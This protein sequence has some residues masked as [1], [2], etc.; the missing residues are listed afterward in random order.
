[1]DMKVFQP[2]EINGMKLRNRL[3]MP[4][5]LNNPVGENG[6]VTDITVRWFEERAKG[7]AGL[8][9][10][11]ACF[12][13]DPGIPALRRLALSVADDSCISGFTRMSKAVQSHGAA[14]GVQIAIGGPMLGFS[15]S[16]PPYPDETHAKQTVAE[17]F[18]QPPIPIHDLSVE[19]IVQFEDAFAAAAARC[20]QAGADCV[21]LHCTHGGASLCSTFISPFYN[22]RD[23]EYGG[24]WEGR[25]RFA[26]ETIQKMR[27]AVGK[28]YPILV[29]I[30]AD[31]LLGSRGITVEDTVK[32]VVPALEEAGVNCFDVS[33]G[34]NIRSVEGISIPLY[35][36]R[37]CFI[38]VAEAVKKV[39][40]LPVI[41]VGRIIEIEMAEK[42]IREGKAD[43]IFMGRQLTADP[44]TP[45]KYLDG[46]P[47]DIRK[48]IG[49]LAGCGRPCPINYDIQDEPISMTPAEK[50]KSVMVIGGGV[51]GMEAARVAAL[52]GHQVTLIEKEPELGGMVAALGL[53]PLTGEFANI[54]DYLTAQMRRLEVKVQVCREATVADIE[55]LKPDVVILATGSTATIPEP[56]RGKLGVMT[57]SEASRNYRAIG[58]NVV[59]YGLF[60]AELAIYL[61]E[62]GK[63]VVL[64]GRSGEGSLGSD[65][66][67]ARKW[68]IIRKLTDVNVVRETPAAQ[69]LSNPKVVFNVQIEDVTTEGIHVVDNEGAKSVLPCDTL[70]FSRRFGER[71][72]N[73]SLFD[74]LQTKVAEVYKIGDCAQVRGIKDAVWDANEVARRI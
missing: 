9:M 66:A 32:Y 28:D 42:F 10:T 18:G 45:N 5:F 46:R 37:G 16:P 3:G 1:M 44:D 36:P 29:R 61:A 12:P 13:F 30:C 71:S 57:H 40:T 33:Q 55:E 52:R 34:D 59:V 41:G 67:Q 50:S 72:A 23:D 56:A 68:W 60:G 21:E 54:I 49:C 43:I 69:K 8:V 19:E 64:M 65:V 4:S 11:G 51:G 62:Q 39:T 73:D 27:K 26:V 7:G 25:L 14:L 63:D 35:Y 53:N 70:I 58:Q 24:D 17:A 74:V 15:P 2:I 6:E 48:C 38:Y 22:K 20:K 47:E 31:Q